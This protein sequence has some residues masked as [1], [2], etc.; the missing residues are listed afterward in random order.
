M[1]RFTPEV[2]VLGLSIGLVMSLICYLVT[3]LS[4]G[5]MI[6]PAW[7]ALLLIDDAKKAFLVLAVVLA[8]YALMQ[9]LQKVV[10]LYGKRLFATVVLVAV[11]LQTTVHIVVVDFYPNL[12]ETTT[13]GFIVPG[14]V[15]YQLIRQP[16]GATLLALGAVTLSTYVVMLSGVLLRFI[17]GV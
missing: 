10:I 15:A 2:A 14:L 13:L 6:S 4:P 16:V 8:T 12:F 9:P 1:S 11:F 17:P 3:N 7:L 5:G